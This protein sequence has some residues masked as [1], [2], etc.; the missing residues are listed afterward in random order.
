MRFVKMQ[1]TMIVITL[2]RGEMRDNGMS[3][4]EREKERD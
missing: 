4:K 2:N 3:M 1:M